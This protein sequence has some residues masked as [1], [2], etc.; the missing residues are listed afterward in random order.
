MNVIYEEPSLWQRV[1]H[2]FTGFDTPLLMAI[3]LL[4]GAGL[5]TMYSAGFDHGSLQSALGAVTG[6]RA[7]RH[8][9]FRGNNA[10]I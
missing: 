5:L 9:F 3:V 10:K 8:I 4:A 1:R 7:F 2:V 6:D